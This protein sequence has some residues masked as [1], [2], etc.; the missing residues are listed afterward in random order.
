MDVPFEYDHAE[1]L[2]FGGALPTRRSFDDATVVIL[3]CPVDRT[4]S[5][6]SGTRNGRVRL[7]DSR[8]GSVLDRQHHRNGIK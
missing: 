2:V 6:V 4:T 5:Y 3:P 7:S 8:V 1:P